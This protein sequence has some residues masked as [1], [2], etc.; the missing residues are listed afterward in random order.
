MATKAKTCINLRVDGEIVRT[1]AGPNTEPGGSEELI[2]HFW[3]VKNLA[4]KTVTIQIV[5][6]ATGGWGHVNVDHIVLT[7]ERPKIPNRSAIQTKQLT[8]DKRYLLFPIRN[9]ARQ[10]RIDLAINGTNVREFDAELARTAEEASFWSFLD[11]QSFNGQT[12][13]LSVKGVAEETLALIVQ[14]DDIPDADNFY[15]ETL[16]P[17]F[18]FSQM[19]GWNN[20]PNGM[21]YYDGEWHLYFQHNPY[22]WKWGNMHWGHAVSKDLV[23]WEQ[24]PI[25]IYNKRRG[26]YAFSGGAVVDE[27]NTT[28][29]QTGD[30]K[31]IVA[32]WTSTGRGECVAYSNDRGRTFTEYEGNPVVKHE[33]RDPKIIWYEPGKHWVM[34]VYNQSEADGQAIAFYS[35]DDMKSWK[36][37]SKL[38]GYYECPELFELPVD[39][40]EDHSRWIVF[41]ADARYVVGTFDGKTFKPDH[42][43]KHQLHHGNYYASQTF[44]NSPDGRR[45]QIGWARIPM[46]NMPFNQTFTFP[47]RLTL[48]S[49]NDGIRMFA[50]PVEEIEILHK[51]KHLAQDKELS[52]D[53]TVKVNAAG[54]IFDIRATFSIDTAT[55]VGLDIGGEVVTYD[56]RQ[57]KLNGADLK[58][59]DGKLKLQ[60]LVDRPMLEIVGNDGRV[61]I[62]QRRE[63]LGDA[64]TIKA[65]ARGG[66][67]RLVQLEVIELNSIWNK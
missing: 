11:V 53:V 60:V 59:V 45:I 25:A 24:L 4:G 57:S 67:A 14:S 48:R 37:T 9:G 54:E 6:R 46:P 5:D 42:S 62:T 10:C 65:F 21:V 52:D 12:G 55:S 30:E 50:E 61:Y 18:H 58:A 16:R 1:A 19:L 49:T 27:N 35:S 22:G 3:D 47:H 13:T 34:V 43:G 39:G 63:A 15:R 40:D 64:E 36:L 29:W 66:D 8:F 7:N 17:Q 33:G 2:P 51:K 56:V 41:A 23:H 31:V 32:S 38:T 44:S 20:D 28:G 26:D